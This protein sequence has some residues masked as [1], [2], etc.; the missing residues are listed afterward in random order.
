MEKVRY[1]DLLP[2]EFRQRLAARPVAYLPLGTLEWHGE[3]DL[4]LSMRGKEF[5]YSDMTKLHSFFC[6]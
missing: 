4:S 3:R 1:A 6:I 5:G 2:W